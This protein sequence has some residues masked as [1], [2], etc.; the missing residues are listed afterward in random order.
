MTRQNDP[1]FINIFNKFI[2]FTHNIIDIHTINNLCLKQPPNN[3]TI[4]HLYYMNKDTLA[5]NLKVFD[6]TKGLTY[7]LNAVHIK[8]QSLS[9]KF[10]IPDDPSKTAG[11]HTLIKVKKNMLVEL[12]AGNYA[13]HDGLVNGADGLFKTF[14]LINSKTYIFIEFLNTKIG[15]LTR[16]AN[17]HLYKD[18]NIDRT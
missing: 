5:H 13:T 16:L 7:Y 11:L 10:K 6:N 14:M 3:S 8:H 2:K 17:A 4:P 12:C 15:S 9:A 18:K 1:L